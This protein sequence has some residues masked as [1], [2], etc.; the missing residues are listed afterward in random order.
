MIANTNEEIFRV[1]PNYFGSCYIRCHPP[2]IAINNCR[3]YYNSRLGLA[4]TVR[5]HVVA[6]GIPLPGL[7]ST[8]LHGLIRLRQQLIQQ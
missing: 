5:R 6:S 2:L 8:V 4:V 3:Y 7:Q 1:L